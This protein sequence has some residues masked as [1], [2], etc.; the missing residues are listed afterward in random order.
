M[1]TFEFSKAKR[2]AQLR[3]KVLSRAAICA[4]YTACAA[5]GYFFDATA[6][7]VSG[8]VVTAVWFMFSHS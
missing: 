2:K 8:M 5:L 6:G 7:M 4:V 1:E 3:E